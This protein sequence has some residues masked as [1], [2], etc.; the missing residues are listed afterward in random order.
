M[1]TVEPTSLQPGDT[2]L[3]LVLHAFAEL[4]GL[5]VVVNPDVTDEVSVRFENTPLSRCLELLLEA[6]SLGWV[7]NGCTLRFAKAGRRGLEIVTAGA[8]AAS[9]GV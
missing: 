4:T 1:G 7:V 2:D 3:N 8:N 6:R 9:E 5:G